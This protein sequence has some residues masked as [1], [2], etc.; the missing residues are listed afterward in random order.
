[1]GLARIS[2]T[3]L[4]LLAI[5]MLFSETMTLAELCAGALCAS[6][7]SLAMEVTRRHTGRR[8]AV[9]PW[10]I[11]DAARR[12]IPKVFSECLILL[13]VLFKPRSGAGGGIGRIIAIP[14][15]GTQGRTPEEAAGRRALV[16]ASMC[17]APNTVVIGLE[18][19]PGHL[20]IH[21]LS[22]SDKPPGHGDPIWPS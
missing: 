7:A 16:T 18:M 20:L 3:W 22:P 9:R 1:V 11:V 2:A 15:D 5:Y 13:L 4:A 12:Q 10:W 6:G 19:R 17:F 8:F 14:F 21:E